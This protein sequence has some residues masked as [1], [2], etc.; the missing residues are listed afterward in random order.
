MSKIPL[1]DQP[2]IDKIAIIVLKRYFGVYFGRINE[3]Q[4]KKWIANREYLLVWSLLLCNFKGKT[5]LDQMLKSS[6]SPY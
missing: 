1:N 3:L 4:V 6:L 2:P 5:T